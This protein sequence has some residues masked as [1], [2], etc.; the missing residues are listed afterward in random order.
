LIDA[1]GRPSYDGRAKQ[2][3]RSATLLILILGCV[4]AACS[5]CAARNADPE[6]EVQRSVQAKM[7]DGDILRADIYRPAD[8]DK[9]PVLLER[10]PYDRQSRNDFGVKAARRGFIYVVQDVRGRFASDGAWYPFMNESNDGYDT[11]EW[12]AA[13]P[14]SDGRVGMMGMSYVGA[15]QLLAAVAQPP[16]L[17][18]IFPIMTA[19][20]YYDG[21]TYRGGAL[22]QWF[23]E[24]WSSG[25]SADTLRQHVADGGLLTGWAKLL[26]LTSF[27][28]FNA[29]KPQDLAPYFYDWLAHPS[30]D[31]YWKRWAIDSRYSKIT[32]PAAHAGGWYDIFLDG[33]LRN[34]VNLS[35]QPGAAARQQKLIV[36]PWIHGPLSHKSSDIDFGA[37]AEVNAHE[38]ILSWYEALF[39]GK[40]QSESDKPVKIFVMGRNEW[41]DEDA[42]PLA[43]AKMTRYFLH[44]DGSA[45]TSSGK[46]SLSTSAPVN[47]PGDSFV[48]DPVDPVPTRGGG[49]CC[50]PILPS[51]AWD[52]REI[53]TR[54]DVLVYT[55]PAFTQATEVTGPIDLDL[56]AS[57]S[58][59]DTDFTAKL[60]DVWPNG[61]AQNLTDGILRARYRNSLEQPEMLKPG[62]TFELTIHALAT[63][64]VFLPGHAVRLEI[65]SS[66]FPHY[67]RNL[68][69][70]A[71]PNTATSG[72]KATNRIYHDASHPSAVILPVIP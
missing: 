55:T 41:R 66:N 51:G 53:E 28:V 5:S 64:N 8:H 4:A 67:S 11:I 52:Q 39:M 59:V 50:A 19:S 34:F 25:L 17:A 33:T 30:Y 12:A 15:T 22:Q 2:M 48:Y 23:A 46:G 44:S 35:A 14:G 58:A 26:P 65:S 60:V 20:N 21:W 1:F 72:V 40:K 31:E 61:Y 69:T 49:L 62:E 3:N 63:S 7:R 24:S 38:L 43:R 18:G 54:Q 47:E 71:D 32:V 9:H 10:T 42:W 36:G 29:G 45:K 68:N 57:S 70:A 13:L 27:P 6:I 16:H 37:A 56:F